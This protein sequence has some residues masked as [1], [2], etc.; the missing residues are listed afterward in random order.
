MSRVQ[1]NNAQACEIVRQ[2]QRPDES[3]AGC[4]ARLILE[5][6]GIHKGLQVAGVMDRHGI[7]IPK[8]I[9]TTS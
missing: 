3:T 4:A 8:P 2:H 7:V 9:R 1:I 5:Y 6:Q